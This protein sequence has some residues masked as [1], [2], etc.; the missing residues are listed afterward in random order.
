MAV[1]M[2]AYGICILVLS[3]ILSVCQC[4]YNDSDNKITIIQGTP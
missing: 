2:L 4:Q 1:F 3:F